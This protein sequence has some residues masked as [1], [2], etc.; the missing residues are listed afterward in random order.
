MAHDFKLII[1]DWDGTL[2][3]SADRIVYAV[4]AG[5]QHV[6][7]PQ[8]TVQEVRDIIGLGLID[9]FQT[10][11]PQI[12]HTQLEPFSSAYRDA[13][14]E[15]GHVAVLFDGVRETLSKL[16][17]NYSLA[18]ATGKSRVGLDR[19]LV[20]T[21]LDD[22]FVATRCADETSPKPH[23]QMLHE[24]FD[25][26]GFAATESIMVGDTDHDIQT[27]RN[28]NI[29]AVAVTCGAQLQHRLEKSKPAAILNN[30]VEFPEWLKTQT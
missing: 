11:Y 18:V 28:A 14:L 1:F 15:P 21:G 2:S 8:R 29:P 23:P 12:D 10:L 3:D 13:Y 7:L 27:A 20:E 9:S 22:Y 17:T 5:A 16:R 26:T 4:N 30:V 25:E 6:G 19:E 24:L